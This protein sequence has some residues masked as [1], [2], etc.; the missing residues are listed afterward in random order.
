MSLPDSVAPYAGTD[1]LLRDKLE[2]YC[3]N[4]VKIATKKPGQVAPFI[5]NEAQHKLH[6]RIERQL[7]S[8]G[9]VRALILKARQLGISTY[10]GA[11]F[12]QKSTLWLGRKTYILT[13][14]DR[15]TQQLFGMVKRIHDN[16]PDEYRPVTSAANANELNFAG[17]ESGYLVGT[18]HNT[19]GGGRSLTRQLFHGSEV[20]FWP[21]ADQHFAAALQ[22]VPLEHETEI[23]LE[24]T[25]NGVGGV[26]Y[27]Q[28]GLAE[29]G[30]SDFIPIFLPWMMEAGYARSLDKEYEP[31][32]EE[33]EYQRLYGLTDQQLCWLHY[34]NVE[35]GGEPGIIGPVFRQEYPAC[36]AEAFQTTGTDSYIPSEAILRARR[37]QAPDQGYLPRVLGVD[38]ARGGSD[39]TRLVDRQGRKAGRIDAVMHT[40][41]LVQIAHEVMKHLRDNPDIRRAYIDITGLGAGVYDICRNNGFDK[42]VAGV[43]FGSKAQEPTTYVNRRAEMWGRMKAWFLDPTGCDIPD[44]DEPHRHIAAPSYKYDANSRLQLEKKEDMK[45][46]LGFSPDWGDALGLTFA[47]ILPVAEPDERP[48]WMREID[49]DAAGDFMTA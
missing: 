35:L 28:W 13:H 38:V 3:R 20:A 7:E 46:R 42:R 27:D 2:I 14:E 24:S 25:A 49:A 17:M 19:K 21:Q 26:F 40:D 31:S 32:S 12:Y 4:L 43:N 22:A 18:A 36:A 33:E 47:E 41:D 5:W 15:A 39:R 9:L 29:R 45:K 16:M 30:Q 37:W 48:K 10:V 1:R 44:E 8:R 11:R 6:E 23:I 34:K